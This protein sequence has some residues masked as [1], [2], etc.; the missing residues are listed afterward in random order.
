MT[1]TL[2]KKSCY[3][4]AYYLG[5]DINCILL[6]GLGEIDDIKKLYLIYFFNAIQS[7]LLIFGIPGIPSPQCTLCHTIMK[8]S[9]TI[10]VCLEHNMSFSRRPT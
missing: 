10:L 1:N 9:F 5:V 8:L 6:D 4:V 3:S 2:I 7:L